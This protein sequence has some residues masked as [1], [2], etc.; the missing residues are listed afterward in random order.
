MKRVKVLRV[1]TPEGESVKAIVEHYDGKFNLSIGFI[2][3]VKID[4]PSFSKNGS[5]KVNGTISSYPKIINGITKYLEDLFL[6]EMKDEDNDSSDGNKPISTGNKK[7]TPARDTGKN[8]R[9]GD[10][11]SLH[12]SSR[13]DESTEKSGKR[14]QRKD[15]LAEKDDSE[16]Q[17]KD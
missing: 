11:S 4:N 6:K 1:S 2:E 13:G 10:S 15:E 8:K 17:G 5:I 16:D 12:S 9:E 14:K 7:S 3:A